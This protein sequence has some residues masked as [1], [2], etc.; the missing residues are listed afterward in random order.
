M[1]PTT[2]A[3]SLPKP[4][5][6]AE[7]NKLWPQWRL[8][9]DELA[10][11]KARRHAARAQAAG[12]RRHRHRL[13]RRAV[14]PAFRARLSGIRRRHRFRA[15]GRDGHPRRPL[16]GDGAGGARRAAAARAACTRPKRATPAPIPSA[17]LKITLPGP[18]TIVDTIADA[19]Y[20]DQVKMAMAFAGA[21]QRGSARARSRRRR[22]DPVRRAGLQRL[23][24]RGRRLGHRGAASRHR[25]AHLHHRRAHLLR[26]R[27]QGQYRLEGRR[28]A[29]SG[30]NTRRFFRRWRKSR[31]DQVS[32]EC[33]NSRVPMKLLSLLDGKDVLVGVIDVATDAVETPEQ[34]AARD[35]RGDEIRAA[36]NASSPAPIAAWRRCGAT[37]RTPSSMALGK[38]AALA[39]KSFG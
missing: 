33:I 14:A 32:L 36:S 12:G 22:R 5:W 27:H 7:P 21:A 13:R 10:A 8:A 24:G 1:F 18:M 2:I 6:L 3:G 26:L 35:R 34:V 29:A 38:G 23:H 31:I 39:R 16:Q 20:G 9:G 4:S 37:S 17:K 19:H 30:G 25:R 15:Q 11:G 28:S